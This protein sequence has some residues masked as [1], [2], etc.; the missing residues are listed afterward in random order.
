MS[1]KRILC[2][3]PQPLNFERLP[4]TPTSQIERLIYP[5]FRAK[6]RVTKILMPTSQI[7]RLISVRDRRSAVCINKQ[8]IFGESVFTL[9]YADL[10]GETFFFDLD[11]DVRVL[12]NAQLIGSLCCDGDIGC[13]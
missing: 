3:K 1:Q 12:D 5:L 8:H 7:E 6:A 11:V 2:P 9:A 13:G 10:G 4:K